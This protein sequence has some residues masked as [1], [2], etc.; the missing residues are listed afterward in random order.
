M[1]TVT[2][3]NVCNIAVKGTFDTCQVSSARES[4]EDNLHAF[5]PEYCEGA[6]R[7]P[8]LQREIP[9]RRSQFDQLG[10]YSCPNSLLLPRLLLSP[11]TNPASRKLPDPIRGSDGKLWRCPR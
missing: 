9:S 10:V 11:Q 3:S 5:S 6:V 2:D 8:T 4:W 7:G 1:T